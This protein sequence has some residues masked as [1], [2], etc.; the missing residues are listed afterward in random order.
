MN[1]VKVHF[2]GIDKQGKIKFGVMFFYD[3]YLA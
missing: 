2:E 1:G 3:E